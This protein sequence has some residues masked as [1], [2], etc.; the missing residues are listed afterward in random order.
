M[1]DESIAI[2]YRDQFRSGR[3]K[4]LSDAEG[5]S[6]ILYALERLGSFLTGN[7]GTLGEY[8]KAIGK[9]A[10]KSPLA[11]VDY[12]SLRIGFEDLYTLVREARND[13]LH[14]GAFA[15]HLTSR[16]VELSIVL[17]DA[18]VTKI[19]TVSAY[20]VR[21]PMCCELW[22]PLSLIRQRML[23]NSYSFL[24]V[25]HEGVWKFVSD[26]AL[27]KYL[28]FKKTERKR[29]LAKP[30]SEAIVGDGALDMQ[31]SDIIRVNDNVDN[32][33][34]NIRNIPNLVL[35]DQDRLVGILA[36]FDLL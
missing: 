17:E 2:F 31:K 6:E 5:F 28:R 34:K 25:Q 23:A 7:I 16:V 29:R 18:L 14:Q 30:L 11:V 10:G 22:Q 15:R 3:A 20:M 4:A 27:A 33:A 32:I 9:I 21:D 12:R 36:A 19:E 24:P 26:Q 1:V 8:Q 35:D 13:A